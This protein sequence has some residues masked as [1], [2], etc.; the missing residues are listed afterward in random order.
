MLRAKQ[1]APIDL[2]IFDTVF[3]LYRSFLATPPLSTSEGFPTNAL[4]GGF[5]AALR[6]I[7]EL[8]P[9]R[10]VFALEGGGDTEGDRSDLFKGYKANRT[11]FPADFSKQFSVFLDIAHK[12]GWH[13][14][15]APGQEADDVIASLCQ[16]YKDARKVIFTTDKDILSL[17]DEN[18]WIY[19]RFRGKSNLLE[20]ED[21]SA[22]WGNL[23]PDQILDVL[24]L[25]GDSVDNVPGVSGIG[26]KSALALVGKYGTAAAV[27]DHL[28]EL[29]KR[30][31][32]KLQEGQEAFQLSSKLIQLNRNLPFQ[33]KDKPVDLEGATALATEYALNS[34]AKRFSKVL[35]SHQQPF[36][37]CSHPTTNSTP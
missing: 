16:T 10:V 3:V 1:A 2:L 35:A 20:A 13:C 22:K 32:T 29:P 19:Q 5:G 33:I 25:M 15:S 23:R 17:T 18:T 34:V 9:K 28:D 24:S 12:L 36:N 30:Q 26:K 7:E 11:D 4:H 14:L 21:I 27:Y 8:K 37:S 31:A 6:A